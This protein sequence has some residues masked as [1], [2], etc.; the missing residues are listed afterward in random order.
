[1]ISAESIYLNVCSDVLR[2]DGF[3]NVGGDQSAD[4]VVDLKNPLPFLPDSV[5]GIYCENHIERMDRPEI[6]AFFRECRR[7][8]KSGGIVRVAT[9]DL[10]AMVQAFHDEASQAVFFDSEDRAWTSNRAGF[11]N[12]LY[13]DRGYKWLLNFEELVSIGKETGFAS[14]HLLAAEESNDPR[15]GALQPY[16][17]FP[18]IV[19]F[20]KKTEPIPVEPL[21]SI[22]I[23]AYK[24]QFFRES[25]LSAVNQTYRNI[26]ILVLDD[27]PSD[28]IEDIAQEFA[29]DDARV[30]YIR[31]TPALGEPANLSKAISLA[32]GEF[33]KPLYDDDILFPGAT[34]ALLSLFRSLPDARLAAGRR[35]FIDASSKVLDIQPEVTPLYEKSGRL[36]GPKVIQEIATAGINH[37]GEPTVV[38]F[39]RQDALA[40]NEPNV[41]S[42]FGETCFGLGDLATFAHLLS[43]GDLAYTTETIS[44]FRIHADQTQRQDNVRKQ[45]PTVWNFFRE[46]ILRLGLALPEK[47]SLPTQT[48]RTK[49]R[50]RLEEESAPLSGGRTPAAAKD[51]S[52]RS[53]Y[54]A[55]LHMRAPT[56]GDI[57]SLTKFATQNFSASISFNIVVRLPAE[58]RSALADTLDSLNCQLY[59]NWHITVVT[60]L[61][62]PDGLNAVP[63][64][65]WFNPPEGEEKT[66]IDT[67]AASSAQSWIVELPP[68]SVL[69]PLCLWRLACEI[70][71]APDVVAFFVDDD[72]YDRNGARK[73]PRFKPGTNPAWLLSSDLAGPLFIRREVW[74]ACGGAGARAGSPWFEQLIRLTDYCGW[75]DIRHIPDVLL[76]YPNEYPADTESCLLA[77]V[78]HLYEQ[79]TKVELE[80]AS[81]N[82]WCIRYPLAASP[83]LSIVVIS[84][85]N[86]DL[87]VRCV[88]SIIEQTAYPD[89][90]IVVVAPAVV[91]DI[92]LDSWLDHYEETTGGAIRVIR[93]AHD[94]GFGI[95]CNLAAETISSELIVFVSEDCVVVHKTWVD[96]LVRTVLQDNIAAVS[97]RLIGSGDAR[98]A[99]AG[100]VLGLDG[101][102][103]SP[104]RENTKLA[105]PGYLD[106]L[107]VAR[108]VS[109]LPSSCFLVRTNAFKELGGLDTVELT[110][111]T[112]AVADLCQKLRQTGRRLIYQPL[113]SV[114]QGN[115]SPLDATLDREK[116]AQAAAAL[117]RAES[118]FSARWFK[119]SACEPYWNP[120]FS[121]IETT[122]VIET[123]YLAQWQHQPSSAPRI[124]ARNLTNGQGDFRITSYLSAL[125]RAGMATECVWP[126]GDDDRE[127]SAT[128][129][130][131]L[132]PDSIIVQHYI[133]DPKLAGLEAWQALPNR[134]FIVYALDDLLTN[135]AE[136]NPFRKNIP[137][138]T[139][140]RLKYA[141]ERCDR[142]VVSTDFLAET[143]RH[144]IPDI[145]VIPNRLEQEIWLPLHSRK[146]T[147]DKPRIGWA[148]GTTHQGD[149]I[150]LKEIIEQ[151]RHEADWI[152]FGM[153][154]DEIRPLIA[155]Y[156]A[157]AAFTEYPA[158]LAGLNLDIAVAPLAQIPFNQGKS[159]LRLLEYGIL[160]I[161]VV[162]TDIDPYRGSPACCVANTAEAWTKALRDR[163]H[164]ADARE[165][166]GATMRQWVHQGY[167][168]ENH[169]EEWL[170]AHLPN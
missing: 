98:I 111:D 133:N 129:I 93:S 141:L 45:Y 90:E 53:T 145:R 151:T 19:E 11:I 2:R 109:A 49:P 124:M 169:L 22:V 88:N 131:R 78:Q 30:T 51:I 158:R 6:L 152:F 33:I 162:C 69:D 168:L 42:L 153:C 73:K 138:N 18:L 14:M 34:S 118:V 103:G 21:V 20:I 92:E 148:G 76:S 121:L 9:P 32:R 16:I 115:A 108:D 104:Y 139:R 160:G 107:I 61:G 134:P 84:Q 44:Q 87:L 5:Q 80:A 60:Q 31:N 96:E 102:I 137:A 150:L 136:S 74:N 170:T 112:L 91:N 66:F 119:N 54:N 126:Q 97:P 72:I 50:S 68:G 62:A 27:S 163:I 64:L 143:Y 46:S 86:L 17:K 67:Q 140:T 81:T 114:V 132:A 26:E 37:I 146:R 10:D 71:A 28:F 159:N 94:D 82:S 12:G 57:E 47:S 99:N 39:R 122:P 29:R 55:W 116:S 36:Y 25:L 52:D 130:L 89:F 7:V 100:N 117:I 95:Q 13:R 144:L 70:T 120:N 101:V 128:E 65:N 149:L 56:T 79:G 127:P 161:P 63:C 38:M 165:R 147:A 135:M 125:R 106:Y 156:H 164:D 77:L 83:R 110:S 24:P 113:A 85:G 43:M 154:P 1:M 167:L 48:L 155:E 123:G 166:E 105:T 3:L 59:G 23:P 4:V 58:F 8:L 35:V 15:L 142:M 40:I 157:L 41:M 75:K